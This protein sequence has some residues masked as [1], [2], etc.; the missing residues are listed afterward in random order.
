MLLQEDRLELIL[1]SGE[2][3]QGHKAEVR[4]R[5]LAQPHAPRRAPAPPRPP[6][7]RRVALRRATPRRAGIRNACTSSRYLL[8]HFSLRRCSPSTATPSPSAC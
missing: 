6:P 7:P 4:S 8:V 3:N 2:P 1:S 5:R